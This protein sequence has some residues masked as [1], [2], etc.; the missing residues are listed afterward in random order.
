MQMHTLFVF[1]SKQLTSCNVVVHLVVV[2]VRT[3]RRKCRWA[4]AGAVR[5]VH[6][7]QRRLQH[8]MCGQ[9][10]PAAV[11]RTRLES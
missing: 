11:D 4:R 3:I 7:A 10:A 6:P 5:K 9:G 8:G 1:C 2:V